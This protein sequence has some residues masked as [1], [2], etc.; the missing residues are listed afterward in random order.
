MSIVNY[1][2]FLLIDP[3]Y[4]G[5]I[6]VLLFNH[7]KVDFFVKKGD[8]V[9]QLI[10][11]KYLH[12]AVLIEGEDLDKTERGVNGF[13]SSGVRNCGS[14]FVEIHNADGLVVLARRDHLELSDEEGDSKDTVDS[15][16]LDLSVKKVVPDGVC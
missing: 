1:I 2:N 10:L 16:P 12:G 4:R 3:D 14:K 15:R 6:G 8:R 5:N 9:A 11:E 13:G 7:G